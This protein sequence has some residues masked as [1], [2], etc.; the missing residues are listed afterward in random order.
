MKKLLVI[1]FMFMPLVSMAQNYNEDGGKYEVYCKVV[2][3]TYGSALYLIIN[4]KEYVVIDKNGDKIKSKEVTEVLNLLSKRGWKL[5]SSSISDK[6]MK[7]DHYFIM[8]KE[9]TD[10]NEVE[11][12]LKLKK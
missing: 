10:D 9:I 12:G 3:S 2:Y 7:T 8:K 11:L 4:D 5:V 1:L 6:S